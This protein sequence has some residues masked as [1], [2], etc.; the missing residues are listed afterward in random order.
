MDE[1]ESCL[2][3]CAVNMQ[4]VLNPPESE[5]YHN[6]ANIA[7]PKSELYRIL[8]AFQNSHDYGV[9]VCQ[10]FRDPRRHY[11][12]SYYGEVA[13][14]AFGV[15]ELSALIGKPGEPLTEQARQEFTRFASTLRELAERIEYIVH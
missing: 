1:P 11:I 8:N 13:D 5:L 2:P 4:Q 7:P 6:D 9:Y 14:E 10:K 3:V 12:D 15:V